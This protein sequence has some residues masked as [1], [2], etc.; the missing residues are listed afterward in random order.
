MNKVVAFV[1][2]AATGSL[3]TWKILERKYNKY[4]KIK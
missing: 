1:L 3:V 2:G 4:L